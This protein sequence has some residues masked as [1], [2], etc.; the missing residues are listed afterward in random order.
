MRAFFSFQLLQ[1]HFFII[2]SYI[3]NYLFV[4]L[5]LGQILVQ[6]NYFENKK[7]YF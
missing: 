5:N 1:K 2:F 6:K 3:I 7:Q 4:N